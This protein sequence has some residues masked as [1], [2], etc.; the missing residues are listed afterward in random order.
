M[1]I[2]E[3]KIITQLLE[4]SQYQIWPQLVA[5]HED[6]SFDAPPY[7]TIEDG[8][9]NWYYEPHEDPGEDESV[10]ICEGELDYEKAVEILKEHAYICENCV[11]N[12]VEL[13]S[14][15]TCRGLSRDWRFKKQIF[16][17][18]P[19]CE[20]DVEFVHHLVDKTCELVSGLQQPD[21]P[22]SEEQA[23]ESEER[24][25]YYEGV[26]KDYVAQIVIALTGKDIRK[27]L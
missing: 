2:S 19:D 18:H 10:F 21:H 16:F 8:Y 9:T 26:S 4:N 6:R 25:Q 24:C 13:Y 23:K 5:I 3:L 12:E 27:H 15:P 1:E 7:G 14:K 22:E 20:K 17:G 11:T